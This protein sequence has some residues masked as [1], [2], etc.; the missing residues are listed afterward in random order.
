MFLWIFAFIDAFTQFVLA[1][2]AAIWYFSQENCH[3]PVTRSIYRGFRFHMG[4]IAFGALL[5]ALV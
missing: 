1:S 5:V 4:S 3:K 2:T